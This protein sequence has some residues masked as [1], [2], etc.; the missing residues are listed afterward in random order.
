[1]IIDALRYDYS[2]ILNFNGYN[3][4][5]KVIATASWTAPSIMG[6][7]TGQPAYKNKGGVPCSENNQPWDG[8]KIGKVT[9]FYQTDYKT[10]FEE[11]E[12]VSAVYEIPFFL[13]LNKKVQQTRPDMENV[14]TKLHFENTIETAKKIFNKHTDDKSYFMYLHFK[15]PHEPCVYDMASANMGNPETL[16]K[17]VFYEKEIIAMKTAIEEF[18]AS[19]EGKFDQVIIASDH[20]EL[21]LGKEVNR[22]YF[23]KH[24]YGHG[25]L[26]NINV[27]HTPVWVKDNL[28]D[29]LYANTIIYDLIKGNKVVSNELV[30]SSSPVR[31]MYNRVG[32]TYNNKNYGLITDEVTTSHLW[33][34]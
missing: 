20:G 9:E 32:I 13:V 10:L 16:Y 17:P 12:K 7:M 26:F 28:P 15:G 23:D 19:E 4:L 2:E 24:R 27:L 5:T 21:L 6:M 1:M 8:P 14:M 31:G 22:K 30:F 18:I 11:F 33:K 29:K 25:N 34:I 3:K